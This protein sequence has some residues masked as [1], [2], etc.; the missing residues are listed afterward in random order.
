MDASVNISGFSC[1]RISGIGRLT[2]SARARKLNLLIL[3]IFA[4]EKK[5]VK[6]V[7]LRVHMFLNFVTT[8]EYPKI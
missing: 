4:L 8:V 5:S 6:D 7:F 1:D 3:L 2:S